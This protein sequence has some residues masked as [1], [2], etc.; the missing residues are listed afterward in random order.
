MVKSQ[1]TRSALA[2]GVCLS[3]LVAASAAAQEARAPSTV[4]TIGELVVT[5]T[6]RQEALQDVPAAVSAFSQ[7]SLRMQRL[8]TGSDLLP[9]GLLLCSDV[10]FVEPPQGVAH[11]AT[12]LN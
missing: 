11:A 8:E 5:A 2:L 6:R 1:T 10:I 7:E 12:S 4:P 3:A 9:A